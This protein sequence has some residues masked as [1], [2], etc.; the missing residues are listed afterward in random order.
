MSALGPL[1]SLAMLLAVPAD[2]TAMPPDMAALGESVKTGTGASGIR[3]ERH[4]EEALRKARA[5]RKPVL[6]DFWAEWCGWCHKLDVTTYADA[7]VVK[8]AEHFVA[9]KVDTEGTPEGQAIAF[10]YDVSSLPTIA[11]LSPRGRPLLRINGFQGPGQFP[12]TMES[13]RDVARRVMGWEEALEKRPQDAETLAALGVHLFEQDALTES[14]QLLARAIGVD[15]TRPLDERKRTRM[16]L[17]AI[18]KAQKKYGEAE[19]VLKAGLLLPSHSSDAKIL[20]VLGKNY[21]AWGRRD[22]GRTAL[23]QL[24]QQHAQSDVAV[25]ARETL[26]SLEKK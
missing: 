7:S 14:G 13:A 18:L 21:L 19:R 4:F 8:L 2:L 25:K 12:R 10:R 20:Y 6:V 15:G 23:Q 1:A 22:D 11:F 17:G 24:V 16:L 26:V 9:V 5:A 3:W